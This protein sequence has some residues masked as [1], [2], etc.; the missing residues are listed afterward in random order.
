MTNKKLVM[1]AVAGVVPA[2]HGVVHAESQGA[3]V[4]LINPAPTKDLAPVTGT[5]ARL[6]R[7]DEEQP[8]FEMPAF[9]FF[10][11]PD[12]S[13]PPNP[14]GLYFAMATELNGVVAKNRMQLSSTPFQ[15]MQDGSGAISAVSDQTLA[16]FVTNNVDTNEH[17]NANAPTAMT[18][19]NG[20]AIVVHYNVQL[21]GTNDTKR[22]I[23]A[24]NQNGDVLLPQ[25]EE[26]A[27]NNDDCAMH[28]D[29]APG[30]AIDRGDT[31][32]GHVT[33]LV[34]WGGCNGNGRDNGWAWVST[35]TCNSAT[36]PTS[37]TF[38]KTFDVSM[39]PNE[40]RSRGRC[41]VSTDTS[42]A[43]CTWT[44]GN[45]QPER[46]GV[47]I[48]AISLDPSI[49]GTDQQKA[50]LWKMQ[51]AGRVDANLAA[52]GQRTY[53][54]RA[55]HERIMV[56]NATTGALEPSDK[57]MFR[58]GD[59]VGRNNNKGT[60]FTNK[61]AVIQVDKTQA[62]VKYLVQPTDLTNQLPGL[63]G[64]HLGSTAAVFGPNA[65]P[66]L[67]FLGGSLFGGG[68]PSMLAMVSADPASNYALKT[69]GQMSGAPHD[70]HLYS[71]YLGGNPGNQGRNHSQMMVIANP[72]F[73]KNGSTSKNLLLTATTA[74]TTAT[75]YP[76]AMDTMSNP[77]IK[78]SALMTVLPM[79]GGG[80]AMG[81]GTGGGNGSGANNGSGTGNGSNAGSDNSGGS[82]P[83]TTLG[84]CS[85]TGGTTGLATF[86]LIGLAALI[87][88]RR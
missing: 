83:G 58:Y 39:E 33:Q 22:Y 66:G 27:K 48:G 20:T 67:V 73:G 7:T 8:G 77:A 86:L 61:V 42:Y 3:V 49:K 79:G 60:Y 71:N 72:F 55:I 21:R 16:K 84:G 85:A 37:C 87:R 45:N 25:T 68:T 38:A 81:N 44:A 41:S 53:A 4:S 5:P 34:Q 36:A 17:R 46:N 57:I 18:I 6:K 31:A 32:Q 26:M 59:A 51:V 82:D 28:Q 30:V 11:N 43:V 23:M 56:P 80:T 13:L 70:A 1:F 78:L 75:T 62:N 2:L 88:R 40:E 64:T 12:G 76:G 52:N 9:A 54:Q 10:T 24:F 74:K 15:L 19:N 29:G 69:V 47:W 50:I 14:K 65:T 35:V 63:G